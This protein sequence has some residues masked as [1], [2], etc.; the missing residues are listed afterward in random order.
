MKCRSKTML[1]THLVT[2]KTANDAAEDILVFLSCFQVYSPL[3][4]M[5]YGYGKVISIR[6]D[7]AGQQNKLST[8]FQ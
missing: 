7:F 4:D 2:I 1:F 3:I 5:A 6:G 8:Y